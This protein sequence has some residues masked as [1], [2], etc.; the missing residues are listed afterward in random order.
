MADKRIFTNKDIIL[1][2]TKIIEPRTKDGRKIYI[3][4]QTGLL[5]VENPRLKG[6]GSIG[7]IK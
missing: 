4:N 3:D 6:D 7:R 2:V 1:V 5:C